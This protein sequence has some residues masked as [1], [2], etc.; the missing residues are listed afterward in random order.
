MCAQLCVLFVCHLWSIKHPI[1]IHPFHSP[2]CSVL[3]SHHSV[4]LYLRSLLTCLFCTLQADETSSGRWTPPFITLCMAFTFHLAFG[5]HIVERSKHFSF[6]A[7]KS[8]LLTTQ[9][10]PD[11]QIKPARQCKRGSGSEW[12]VGLVIGLHSRCLTCIVAFR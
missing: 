12:L 7:S 9:L 10:F 6:H 11:P 2:L 3:I 4:F 1:F 5:P 8:S